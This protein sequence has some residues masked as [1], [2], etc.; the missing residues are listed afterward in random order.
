MRKLKKR[1]TDIKPNETHHSAR[2]RKK[3]LHSRAV[4]RFRPKRHGENKSRANRHRLVYSSINAAAAAVANARRKYEIE[5]N[6]ERKLQIRFKSSATAWAIMPWRVPL[7]ALPPALRTRDKRFG[8]VTYC[9]KRV[10]LV[11][12]PAH[13]HTHTVAYVT[14]LFLP[15]YRGQPLEQSTGCVP[16]IQKVVQNNQICPSLALSVH[17]PVLGC[18]MIATQLHSA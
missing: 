3:T 15:P 7:R 9:G 17:V 4:A 11:R 6:F 2:E 5:I 18:Q 1:E 14:F 12:L 8:E 10:L 16:I 13:T